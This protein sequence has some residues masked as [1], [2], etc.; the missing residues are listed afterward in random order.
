M[1]SISLPAVVDLCGAAQ[2]S[3]S[4]VDVERLWMRQARVSH[5]LRLGS[6]RCSTTD[7]TGESATMCDSAG[8]IPPGPTFFHIDALRSGVTVVAASSHSYVPLR[9]G[10]GPAN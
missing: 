9:P 3:D 5:R 7:E 6:C 4:E 8:H 10:R 1:C 2:D